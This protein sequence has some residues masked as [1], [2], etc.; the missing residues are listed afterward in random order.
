MSL[1]AKLI[2][3]FALF[4]VAPIVALG[5]FTYVRS[6]RAVEDLVAT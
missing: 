3:V 4:G 1:R 2:A 6:M 5:V